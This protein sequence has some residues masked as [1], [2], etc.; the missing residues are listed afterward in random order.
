[1]RLNCWVFCW[2]ALVSFGLFVIAG[3]GNYISRELSKWKLNQLNPRLITLVISLKCF[4]CKS[5]ILKNIFLMNSKLRW[6]RKCFRISPSVEG[7]APGDRWEIPVS[8]A[9]M[10]CLDALATAIFEDSENLISCLMPKIKM[11]VYSQPLVWPV[12]AS[13]FSFVLVGKCFIGSPNTWPSS[14]PC[15]DSFREGS[16]P[17]SRA[18]CLMLLWSSQ[19]HTKETLQ[20]SCSCENAC[21]HPTL[22]K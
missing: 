21:Q 9:L 3:R 19:I 6:G 13:V 11:Q 17:T 2:D 12:T 5:H 7:A 18:V 15:L 8:A 14:S 4:K 22:D 16:F 10:G 1:M 20:D